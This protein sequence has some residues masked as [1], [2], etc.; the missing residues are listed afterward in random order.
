MLFCIV[1]N[2][3][4]QIIR[5]IY[6]YRLQNGVTISH[7]LYL[8]DIKL[9]NKREFYI[10]SLIHLTSIYS[11]NI[12]VPSDNPLAVCPGYWKRCK[13]LMTR[14]LFMIHEGFY[15]KSSTLKLYTKQKEGG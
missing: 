9:Y 12:T 6:Q 5:K 4:S 14:T 15:S 3:L 2:S 1:L 11:N 13:Q 7:L 10:H 8:D